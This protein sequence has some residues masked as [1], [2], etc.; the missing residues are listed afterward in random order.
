MSATTHV[1]TAEELIRLPRGQ[2]RYELV[3]G[4]LLTMSPSG[5]PHGAVSAMIGYLL[6]RFVKENNL[7]TV[8]GAETGFQLEREPDTVLAPDAAFI[9]R[10]RCGEL[11][12]GYRSGPPD[13]AVEVIS[14]GDRKTKVEKKTDHWLE[15]GA[16]AVWLINPKLRTVEIVMAG[17]ERTLLTDVDELIDDVVIPGFKGRSF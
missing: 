17:G 1:M 5:E 9:S 15:F 16:K 7:G 4:E 8:F 3:K 2:H 12:Q 14:P 11:S 6:M 13:L 10:S